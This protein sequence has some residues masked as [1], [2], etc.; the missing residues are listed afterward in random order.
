M[1]S[2]ADPVSVLKG[3]GPKSAVALNK[4]GINTVGNLLLEYPF[5]YDDFA[6]RRLSDIADQE[7]VTLKGTVASEAVLTRFGRKKSRLNFRLLVEHDVIMVTFFNQ[8]YLAQKVETGKEMAI[9][10]KWDGRHQR[11]AGM[12]ILFNAGANDIAGVYRSSKDVQQATV[13]KLVKQAYELYGDVLTEIIPEETRRKFKLLP[14]KIMI[15]DMHFPENQQAASLARRS[16]VF[17]EFFRFQVKMQFIK[18]IQHKEHGIKI[19]YD[20]DQVKMFIATLPFELTAAQKKVVNEICSDLHHTVHMNRLLQGD[21]GS[22]KT[23][24]AAIALYAAVTAGVQAALM[25][26]TEILAQQHAEKLDHLFAKFNVNVALL[27]GSTASRVKVRRE[28]LKHLKDGQIDIVVGTHALIQNDVVF[29]NLGLVITDEQHR[30]GVNQR[31]KFKKKGIMP[32]VLAMTATPIPRTLAITMYGEMDV[33]TITELPKGRLP[34]E[35]VWL[36]EKQLGEAIIFL[37]K[38]LS[39]GAQAYVISPLIEESEMMDL[40]NAEEIFAKLKKQMEPEYHVGLLH[41]RMK[42]SEKNE[43]MAAFKN[44]KFD[45]LVSTTVIEVGVDVPN[46]T[47]MLILDADRFGLAQLHQLRGRVGRGKKQ[48][49]C[50]LIADPKNEYGVARMKVM[51][52]TNDGFIIAQKDLELRGQGDILGNKQSG[53]PDFKVGDPVT[54]LRILQA[55]QQEAAQIINDPEFTHKSTNK[56]LINY[57]RHELD[58]GIS[59]D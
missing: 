12:K 19:S 25:A 5:R 30:F 6:V 40:K 35:T 38:Q 37:K 56:G 59:F 32:D 22:G 11:L 10:G 3:V 1:K 53:V 31:Q 55:A 39:F 36:R 18:K 57:L 9:Y 52:E 13:K 8:P 54:D 23:V 2:L 45:I 29:K 34:I 50:F 46:A 51:S 7:K 48:S 44:K 58:K 4:L 20:N 27:T 49:Y 14:R 16:A 21:V 28:L 24:V 43:V 47:M 26:P 17:D 41:G 15:H 42:G 33:S